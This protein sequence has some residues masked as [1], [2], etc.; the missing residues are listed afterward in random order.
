MRDGRDKLK[1]GIV[2]TGRLGSMLLRT[3]AR[4]AQETLLYAAGRNRGQL[5]AMRRAIPSLTVAEIDSVACAAEL[6]ILCVPPDAYGALLRQC[7][8][9]LLESSI[10]VSV[11]NGVPLEAIG[12]LVPNPVVKV[13]PTMAHTVGRG[14]ALVTPGPR[15]EPSHID[16]VRR[17]FGSFSKP[18]LIEDR[19]SRVASNVAGSWLALL[20]AI[21]AIFVRSNETRAFAL[22]RGALEEMMSE[23]IGAVSDLLASGFS[24]DDIVQGTATPGGT[25]EAALQILQERFP[26]LATAMVEETFRRQAIMHG[27]AGGDPEC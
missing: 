1:V 4:S 21:C 24:Y 27:A 6:L 16:V 8:G 10:V 26:M 25:T 20:A 17:F 2:G 3:A 12:D 22:S 9:C 5:A 23:S 11:T 13:I 7:S 19:D 18:I 14:I 15:A